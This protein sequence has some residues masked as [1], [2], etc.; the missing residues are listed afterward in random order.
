MTAHFGNYKNRIVQWQDLFFIHC[1]VI[2]YANIKYKSPASSTFFKYFDENQ[3]IDITWLKIKISNLIKSLSSLN[4]HVIQY[5]PKSRC[6]GTTISGHRAV[7]FKRIYSKSRINLENFHSM[8]CLRHFEEKWKHG[9]WLFAGSKT[10]KK[11]NELWY[12]ATAK[13]QILY[14]LNSATCLQA[15][16]FKSMVQN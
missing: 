10:E 16:N 2:D 3:E 5:Q 13:P 4:P 7:K 12:S 9:Q 1:C 15:V 14:F 6:L 11:H 8:R